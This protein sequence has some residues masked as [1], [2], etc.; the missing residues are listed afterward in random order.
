[1]TM[2]CT[3]TLAALLTLAAH[4]T[5]ATPSLCR[6]DEQ[7][8]FSCQLQGKGPRK[9]VSVCAAR[10]LGSPGA[11]VAYRFGQPLQPELV[12][13]ASKRDS[14][15]AFTRWHYWRFQ[16]D[17][18]QLSFT[19]GDYRYTVFDRYAA[20][21]RPVKSY[22]VEVSRASNDEA[23]RTLHCQ[24]STVRSRLALLAPYV[25]CADDDTGTDCQRPALP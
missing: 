17:Y 12:Y 2:R 7:V 6:A 24:A 19:N 13:P 1:M 5:A 21:A 14:L 16:T 10:D 15:K 22:G 25:P 11:F 3:T 18:Q 20:D 9:L 8:V 23:V 4:A